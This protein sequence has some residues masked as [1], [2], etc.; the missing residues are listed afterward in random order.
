MVLHRI[1]SWELYPHRD[2]YLFLDTSSLPLRIHE[3]LAHRVA[4]QML[5][6]QQD[7]SLNHLRTVG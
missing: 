2:K 1:G 4:H 5:L 6:T 3:T 7:P